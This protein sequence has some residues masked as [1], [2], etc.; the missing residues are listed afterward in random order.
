MSGTDD[1]TQKYER[2]G[3]IDLWQGHWIGD[4][5]GGGFNLTTGCEAAGGIKSAQ[6]GATRF[7][8]A[9]LLKSQPGQPKNK[10]CWPER[11]MAE[12]TGDGLVQDLPGFTPTT[13]KPPTAAESSCSH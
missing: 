8:Q 9:P 7:P 13:C 4:K 6:R 2:R 3:S 1:G 5:E 12:Q 11:S 10:L